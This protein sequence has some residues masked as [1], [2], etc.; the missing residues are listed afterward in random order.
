M[1]GA[2]RRGEMSRT[3]EMMEGL[4]VLYR[5]NPIKAVAETLFILRS[6]NRTSAEDL[7]EMQDMIDSKLKDK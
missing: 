2:T 6:T 1:L 4:I 7:K 3:L 5:D